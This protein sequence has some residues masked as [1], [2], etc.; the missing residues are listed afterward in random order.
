MM[1]LM[2][3]MMNLFLPT[4]E[5]VSSLASRAMD[6]DLPIRKRIAMRMHLW[7]CIWCRRNAGQVK[8]MRNLARDTVSSADG[9]ARLSLAARERIT[10]ALGQHDDPPS[11]T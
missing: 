8:L 2:M 10:R 11:D 4:C 6:E 9:D 3:R 1:K 7:M 5:E